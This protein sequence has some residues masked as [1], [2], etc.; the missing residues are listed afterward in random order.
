MTTTARQAGQRLETAA[1]SGS[2]ATLCRRH[3]IDLMVLF[4][5]LARGESDPADVDVAIA[6]GPQIRLD[7]L[8]LLQDLYELTEYE[9]FDVI[10]LDRAGPIAKERALVGA[11]VLYQGSP[12][13]FANRQIAAVLE[14][15][16]TADMRLIELE[17]M[18][19]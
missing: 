6:A 4:G 10:D 13:A 1:E 2:L 3:G 7:L 18:A 9:D 12:G 19:R 16:D 11:R 8:R 15:I 17:L 14:R 5:S